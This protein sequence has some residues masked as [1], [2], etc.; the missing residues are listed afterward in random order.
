MVENTS[1]SIDNRKQGVR[2]MDISKFA[3]Q[4]LT[5]FAT[6]KYQ[7]TL[8]ADAIAKSYKYNKEH[9]AVD[10]NLVDQTMWQ[11]IRSGIEA[12]LSLYAQLETYRLPFRVVELKI[13]LVAYVLHDLHKVQE[14]HKKVGSEYDRALEE[15]E[16]LGKELCKG[17]DIETP[18]AAFLRVAAVSSLSNKLGD[19]SLL[20]GE[21]RW[22]HIYFWVKLMDK[23]ASITSIAECQKG[24]TLYNLGHLL[25]QLLPPKLTQAMRIEFHQTQEI[26]GMITTLLHNGLATI[27]K[28]WGYYPWLRFGDGTLYITFKSQELPAKEVVIEHLIQMF[29]QTMGSRVDEVNEEDLFDRATFRCQTLAFALY[30]DPEDFSALFYRIFRK[31]S[32]G[33]KQFPEDKKD[34]FD[35]KRLKAYKVDHLAE[36]YAKLGMNSS[37]SEDFREKWA[38]TAKYF[39]ALQRLLQRLYKISSGEAMQKIAEYLGLTVTDILD[40]VPENMQ[41]NSRRFDVAIWLSYRYLM[42]TRVD[43]Y[44]VLQVPIEDFYLHVRQM[45][46]EFLQ[47]KVTAERCIEIAESEMKLHEELHN[48]FAEEVTLSWERKRSLNLLQVKELLKP[49][50]RSQKRICNICNRQ[51]LSGVDL[52]IKAPVI[53]DD[54]QVFS[55]RLLPKEKSVSALHWCGVCAFEYSLR[56][57]YKMGSPGK[58][59][60]SRQI[61]LFAVPSFQLTDH[62]LIE[63][64][65]DLD[66]DF[67][68]LNLHKSRNLPTWQMPFLE[69]NVEVLREHLKTHFRRYHEY[70]QITLAERGKL[71]STGDVMNAGLPGNI[72]LFTFHCYSN[73]ATLVRT[74]EEAWMKAL[75]V[76]LSLHTIYGFR[77]MVTEKAFLPLSE[78]K[79]IRYAIHLDAPPYKVA[80]LLG[81]AEERGDTDFIVP[82]E[83]AKELIYRL[84]YLWEIHQTVHPLDYSKPTDKN[85]STILHQFE[86][87]PLSGAYFFKRCCT[88]KNFTS[89]SF[90]RSCKQI[91]EYKG[92]AMVS[93]AQKI[94][95]ATLA[96]YKP[97]TK[98]DGR[99]HRYEN[100]YRII[101]KGIK[102]GWRDKE[103]LCGAVHKR[104]ERLKGQQLGYVPSP[105]DTDKVMELVNLVYDEFF[106]EICNESIMKLNQKENQLA[107][108]I[109]FAIHLERQKEFMEKD[110]NQD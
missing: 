5:N 17:L 78:I 85:I 99:A 105:I 12:F 83:N 31:Q 69:E 33:S 108:G 49:K 107:D 109:Y 46:T 87:H 1:C 42:S 97:S 98:Q 75:T 101:V 89:P 103:S 27:M 61:H 100:L 37:L 25:K 64:Y 11:H 34:R 84:A 58:Y 21:Y 40:V 13:A 59:G 53:Q 67:T 44:E 28:E 30:S 92:G 38:F 68:S 48:Y 77:I 7:G 9:Y 24:R 93:L 102:E 39:A 16:G 91:D 62:S 32:L 104:L 26:R 74:R 110:K 41:S 76:A 82:V 81:T 106:S 65:E 56:Q 10:R 86:V 2:K 71:P 50:T 73:S 80:K 4:L 54:V 79:D 29:Q 6:L 22:T 23:L 43:G 14:L 60:A 70:L 94:A 36:L 90:I 18:P 72:M 35:A 55:N 45:A 15:L 66:D 19:F 3:E 47:D 51:I 96:L 88:E 20:S 95:L 57:I 8:F 52:V 63:L